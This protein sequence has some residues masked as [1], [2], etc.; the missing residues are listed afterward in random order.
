MKRFLAVAST[1][2]TA[3][4]L[5]VAPTMVAQAA[6]GSVVVYSIDEL[7]LDVYK[8]P[9][10]CKLLPEAAHVLANLTDQ[11]VQLYG[12][13]KCETAGETV[14]ADHGVH[15]PSGTKAFSVS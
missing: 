8:N 2:L 1:V 3:V 10:G 14:P 9:T 7:P 4:A 15:I 6:T 13:T 12:D 11:D 5:A